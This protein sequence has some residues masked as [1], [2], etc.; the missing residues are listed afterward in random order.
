MAHFAKVTDGIVT[1]VIV[2]EQEF[3]DSYQDGKPGMWIQTSYNT[4]GGKHLKGGTPLRKNYAGKG[5]T[6]DASRDAFIPPKPYASWTL[7][8]TTD[9]LLKKEFDIC[10]EEQ[11]PHR[12]FL[13]NNLDHLV[14]FDHPDI[15][16]WR[17]S[18]RAGLMSRHDN[19]NIIL[20]GGV[21]D[22]WLNTIT[23][24]LIVVD[25][26]SQSNR[27]PV[28]PWSYLSS[29]YHTAYKIQLD[30]YAYLL[31]E[32]GFEVATTGYFLVCNGDK[33]ADSFNGKLEFSE[34]IIPYETETDWIKPEID[35]MYQ[36]MNS[37]NVPSSNPSCENCAYVAR[38]AEM[39][40][41]NR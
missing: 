7:N 13:E 21:D 29:V 10:R 30:F 31:K 17:D 33:E 20:T 18:L 41:L 19:T 12:I 32:M 34:T 28:E 38:R 36:L 2:A 15:E 25:Y 37:C 11:T 24:E 9:R 23:D 40:N 1:T 27:R 4:K 26:K 35:K 22:I 8:E 14:P 3:I 6:Y 5:Y 39:E 16:K